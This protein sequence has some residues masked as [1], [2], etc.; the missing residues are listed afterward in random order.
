MNRVLF[1][2]IEKDTSVKAKHV[3]QLSNPS[4]FQNAY[5]S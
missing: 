5:F 3:Q 2:I 1:T 4:P